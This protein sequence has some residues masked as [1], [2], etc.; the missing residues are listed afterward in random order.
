[1]YVWNLLSYEYIGNV[2]V[3]PQPF[4]PRLAFPSY[5]RQN[6]AAFGQLETLQSVRTA[7]L[8]RPMFSLIFLMMLDESGASS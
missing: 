8:G 6:T 3:A 2:C 1:M 4:L 7:Q 5:H